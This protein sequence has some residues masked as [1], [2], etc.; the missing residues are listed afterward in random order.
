[1]ENVDHDAD[2]VRETHLAHTFGATR[3][4]FDMLA[5]LAT[6]ATPSSVLSRELSM[7]A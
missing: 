5:L 4:R 3:M 1:M 2:G 7:S 6:I